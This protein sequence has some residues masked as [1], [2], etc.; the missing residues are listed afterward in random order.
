ME[1]VCSVGLIGIMVWF[2]SLKTLWMILTSSVLLHIKLITSNKAGDVILCLTLND[3]F[4]ELY[5]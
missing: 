4:L 1:F 5:S 2:L 3:R